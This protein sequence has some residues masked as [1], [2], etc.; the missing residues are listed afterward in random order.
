VHTG[1]HALSYVAEA[2][3]CHSALAPGN[4]DHVQA[5]GAGAAL[6][7]V[8]PPISG[9]HAIAKLIQSQVKPGLLALILKGAGKGRFPSA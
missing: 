9:R 1:Q 7:G 8:Q 6:W 2:H 3:L 4:R 5:S